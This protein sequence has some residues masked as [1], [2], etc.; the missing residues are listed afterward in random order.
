M[1]HIRFGS[2]SLEKPKEM[3]KKQISISTYQRKME[4]VKSKLFSTHCDILMNEEPLKNHSH[5]IHLV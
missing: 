5:F 3:R 4:I 1:L 2:M